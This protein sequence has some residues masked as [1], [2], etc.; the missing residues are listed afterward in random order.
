MPSKQVVVVNRFSTSRAATSGFDYFYVDLKDWG[1]SVPGHTLRVGKHKIDI[2]QETWTDNPIENSLVSNAVS[3][4][5]GYDE[6]INFRGPLTKS[7]LAPTYSIEL[8]NGNKGVVG[9]NSDLAWGLKL[10]VPVKQQLYF[11]GSI[12]RTGDLVKKDGSLDQPDFN[13]AEV[14]DA[15]AGANNWNRELWEVDVR[16]GYGKEGIK[17]CVG[18]TPDQRWQLAAALGRF[19]DDASGA[20]D[21]NGDYWFVEGLYNLTARAYIAGR[22]SA[23]SLDN[24]VLAKLGGSPVAV[25]EYR[26]FSIGMGWRLGLLTHLKAE[27]TRNNT[28]GGT[29]D[30]KLNQFALGLATKF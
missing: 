18:S 19:Q 3:H 14:F 17:S 2:G 28:S 7:K 24:G 4:I 11:S 8:L 15:P 27:Y 10:G 22:Y 9:A 26:R 20:A 30:P 6:G 16:Y 23:I 25:N 29:S 1:G 12:F 13:I 5:S 21:R